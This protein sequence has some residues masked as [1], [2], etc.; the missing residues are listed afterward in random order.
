MK[1]NK[2]RIKIM[3]DLNQNEKKADDFNPNEKNASETLSWGQ[4]QTVL[5]LLTSGS[6][7]FSEESSLAIKNLN[8]TGCFEQYAQRTMNLAELRTLLRKRNIY[9]DSDLIGSCFEKIFEY[10]IEGILFNLNKEVFKMKH[11][12]EEEVTLSDPIHES[13]KLN[14]KIIKLLLSDNMEALKIVL[15]EITQGDIIDFQRL[16][17]EEKR[18]FV[19]VNKNFLYAMFVVVFYPIEKSVETQLSKGFC[20]SCIRI[21]GFFFKTDATNAAHKIKSALETSLTLGK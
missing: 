14:D 4:Y 6:T 3:N 9:L 11:F 1:A 21:N 18:I 12:K 5:R 15:K 17:F 7:N 13:L 8:N 20:L 10:S 16:N 2:I 19:V